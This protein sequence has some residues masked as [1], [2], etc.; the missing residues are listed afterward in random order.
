MSDKHFENKAFKEKDYTLKSLP[1]G[2]YEDCSFISCNFA[3]SD[4]SEMNFVDCQFLNCD[5]SMAELANTTWRSAQFKDCKMLGL[6]FEHCNELLFS[7]A[8]E[9]C[10][11]D[12]SSFY[13]RPMKHT[14]F[15]NCSLQEV[16]FA[17]ADLAGS[18][19]ENCNLSGAI[20][21]RSVLE[22]A[23]FR[24]AWNFIIDPELNRVRKAK[25]ASA[26]LAGLLSK[27]DIE[28]E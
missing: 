19:F 23:D 25:F 4:L 10:R 16:D 11:L 8:F 13:Q 27:Y 3:N 15:K 7:V 12:L 21:E 26:G 2:A 18:T 14:L 22:K 6:H 17:E 9:S 28:V 20:F 24:T 5:L 1:R